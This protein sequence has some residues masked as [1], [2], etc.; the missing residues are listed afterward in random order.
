[1]SEDETSIAIVQG[2]TKALEYKAKNP[3]AGIDEVL[4]QVMKTLNVSQEAKIAA[5]AAASKALKYR[6]KFPKERG[7]DIMQ[8]VLNETGLIKEDIKSSKK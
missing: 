1:M 3:R 7:R 8:R 4:W 2:I 5:I 6:D